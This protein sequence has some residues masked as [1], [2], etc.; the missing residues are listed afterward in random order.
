M[1]PRASTLLEQIINQVLKASSGEKDPSGLV[2]VL[3][4]TA[5]WWAE[6]YLSKRLS[7]DFPPPVPP[8]DPWR[9]SPESTDRNAASSHI[10][11]GVY[12]SGP[13][14]ELKMCGASGH[15]EGSRVDHHLPWNIQQLPMFLQGG[16]ECNVW[17]MRLA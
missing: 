12:S 16:S 14:Q 7:K 15:I 2:V 3:V 1:H 4:I 6:G 5:C 9:P 17:V 8:P 10:G 13:S 11:L